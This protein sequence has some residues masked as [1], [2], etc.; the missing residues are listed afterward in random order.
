M[1]AA[2]RMKPIG[3]LP[4]SPRN[5]FEGRAKVVGRKPARS[6]CQ[7]KAGRGKHRIACRAA[8]NA[9]SDGAGT[10]RRGRRSVK[11]VHQ[12]ERINQT[13]YPRDC[14]DQVQRLR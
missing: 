9:D 4:P 6:A 12:V 7:R 11:V 10:C 13:H 2:A 8:R 14:H 3:M 5:I 1:T